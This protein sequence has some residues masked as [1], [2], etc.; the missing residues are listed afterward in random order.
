MK[1]NHLA[2]GGSLDNAIVIKDNTIMN[3]DFD[4]KYWFNLSILT[5]LNL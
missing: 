2:K 3:N 4:N 5:S 1:K